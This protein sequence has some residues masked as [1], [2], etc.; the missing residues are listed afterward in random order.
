MKQKIRVLVA[1]PGLDGHD[2]GALV[3]AQ[4]LRDAG[5]EVVY[6][7]LRQTP[8][9]IVHAAIQEDVDFIGL[10]CL[11]GA[12]NELFPEV[13]RLLREQQA[14]DIMVFGGGVI[15]QEDIPFLK[16]QGIAEIF[17]PGTPTQAA[18]DFVRSKARPKRDS[19][20]ET[21]KRI[22]HIGIAVQSIE[23][24]LPFYTEQLGLQLKGREKVE[25]EQV[26]VAFLQIGET[27]LEL[28][29]PLSPE[30]PIASFITK[31]GEGIHHIALDVDDIEGRLQQFKQNGVQLVH[32]QA[33]LGAHG[34]Q[35]AFL[36]PKAA[37]GV[38]FEL[39]QYEQQ[40]EGLAD[41]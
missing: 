16:E 18:V 12:H 33:K 38:L 28:L 31:R 32:E 26:E 25:S 22:A 34:A 1:K 2:R 13:I 11:S 5:M 20:H 6:T 41:E 24:V 15:P 23:A 4:S 40:K 36:H 17:T 14:E 10:S 7:G 9:Q 30:S 3:I 21:P 39:C 8:A 37:N 29:E 35:I 27:N 19:W